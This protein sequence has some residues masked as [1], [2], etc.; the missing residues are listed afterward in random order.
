M[1]K[2]GPEQDGGSRSGYGWRQG[3]GAL[4]CPLGISWAGWWHGGQKGSWQEWQREQSCQ[5]GDEG[6]EKCPDPAG[7]LPWCQL[8]VTVQGGM[9]PRGKGAAEGA[10]CWFH[11]S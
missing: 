3:L 8:T 4:L 11:P 9:V 10:Q 7:L 1:G 2:R 5:P 6:A